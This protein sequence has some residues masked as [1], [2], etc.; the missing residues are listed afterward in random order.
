MSNVLLKE[1]IL[2]P[3]YFT[4]ML[5]VPVI[6]SNQVS[7]IVFISYFLHTAAS[8]DLSMLRFALVTAR[9][10]AGAGAGGWSWNGVREK[11]CCAG[12]SWSWLTN[13]VFVSSLPFSLL[14]LPLPLC[15]WRASARPS[16]PASTPTPHLFPTDF[17]R[18]RP[19]LLFNPY[20]KSPSFP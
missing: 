7:D 17:P 20:G 6:F 1:S 15:S 4:R 11:Y 14:L 9:N 19:A 13:G 5:S 3:A 18:T 2:F 12:W 16:F 10:D 8:F